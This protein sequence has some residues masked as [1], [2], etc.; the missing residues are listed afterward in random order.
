MDKPVWPASGLAIITTI[1]VMV[2]IDSKAK[3]RIKTYHE[4]LLIEAKKVSSQ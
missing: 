4:K 1:L 3:A 2:G